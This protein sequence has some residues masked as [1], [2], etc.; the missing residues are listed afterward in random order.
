MKKVLAENCHLV[1]KNFTRGAL[2]HLWKSGAPY[3]QDGAL[4]MPQAQASGAK[5]CGGGDGGRCGRFA[6]RKW[7]ILHA[8]AGLSRHAGQSALDHAA[9][10]AGAATR[11]NTHFG[12]PELSGRASGSS[13]DFICCMARRIRCICPVKLVHASHTARCMRTRN[14]STSDS[15]RSSPSEVSRCISLQVGMSPI[16][17]PF[18]VRPWQ[19]ADCRTSSNPGIRAAGDVRDTA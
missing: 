15:S 12:S 6:G 3:C 9:G 18:M 14:R 4:G 19:A 5:T 8:P 2:A 11:T 13:P 7:R 16:E 1:S 10:K 17:S